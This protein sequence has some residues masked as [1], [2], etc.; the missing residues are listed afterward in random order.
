MP[1]SNNQYKF[2]AVAVETFLRT[3]ILTLYR[4]QYK[5]H[6]FWTVKRQTMMKTKDVA[7]AD[8]HPLVKKAKRK[9]RAELEEVRKKEPLPKLNAFHLS[10]LLEDME[11]TQ[12]RRKH[13]TLSMLA[14]GHNASF[15]GP[16]GTKGLRLAFRRK[17]GTLKKQKISK[18]VRTL[19]TYDI[20]PGRGTLRE[21]AGLD[22]SDDD[23][24]DSD[25]D[26]GDDDDSEDEVEHMDKNELTV[27]DAGD[28]ESDE[29]D[30]SEDDD[31]SKEDDNKEDEDSTPIKVNNK[32][33]KKNLADQNSKEKNQES[34]SKP[35]AKKEPPLSDVESNESQQTDAA[36]SLSVVYGTNNTPKRHRNTHDVGT[37]T[38]S[39]KKVRIKS[40]QQHNEHAIMA[41]PPTNRYSSTN[42]YI[43]PPATPCPPNYQEYTPTHQSWQFVSPPR[44]CLPTTHNLYFSTSSTQLNT[45]NTPPRHE[46]SVRT[47]GTASI[48]SIGG[49]TMTNLE[50]RGSR[51]NPIVV[52]ADIDY[53]ERTDFG[54]LPS[55]IPEIRKHDWRRPAYNL[56]K[57]YHP[58][59]IHLV[60]A[61]IPEPGSVLPEFEERCLLIEEPSVDWLQ[62]HVEE[63]HRSLTCKP[64]KSA[65]GTLQAMWEDPGN[66]YRRSRFFLIVFPNY[67]NHMH[68]SLS[69][70][71]F[72]ETTDNICWVDAGHPEN[73]LEELIHCNSA[74]WTIAL[75]DGGQKCSS[76]TPNRKK[77]R[78]EIYKEKREAA[79]IGLVGGT[80][81]LN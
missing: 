66:A 72:V 38:S 31:N 73:T 57:T 69:S 30:D 9:A 20:Q 14:T 37:L 42:D 65:H 62:R 74:T 23:D 64:T 8:E 56:R 17:L 51:N 18:Y 80:S 36:G 16:K 35:F 75:R 39:L 67:I 28:E 2:H 71:R 49:T 59:D 45:M 5:R 81:G 52:H 68:F 76:E 48:S 10:K 3:Q 50:F 70:D 55:F 33:T 40:P 26:I 34:H 54:F 53:P 29:E 60:N 7:G 61:W 63:F 46:H 12:L 22:E 44:H 4:R 58:L 25:M 79:R 13:I 19:D 27:A 6:T 11:Q 1:Y 21:K 43:L 77:S 41:P 78:A 24:N 32:A 15:Y 47:P